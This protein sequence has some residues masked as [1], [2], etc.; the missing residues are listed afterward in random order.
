MSDLIK[1]KSCGQDVSPK[2]KA[3]PKCG[4]P[5]K[6]K[7]RFL[8]I[9][10]V[11]AI[12]CL[13]IWWPI[14]H[15]I[16]SGGSDSQSE[17]A[18][19]QS[20]VPANTTQDEAAPTPQPD[21]PNRQPSIS[22][23]AIYSFP[24]GAN[25]VWLVSEYTNTGSVGILAFKSQWTIV[26]DLGDSQEQ[27]EDKYTSETPFVET[28]GGTNVSAESHIILPGDT[29]EIISQIYQSDSGFEQH[30]SATTQKN[31]ASMLA[32]FG[33]TN[34]VDVR[35]NRKFTFEIEKVVAR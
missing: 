5:V 27:R 29:I 14:I 15:S 32:G 20:E 24:F 33:F 4:A 11:L 34:L 28:V 10:S 6:R 30:I 1:C 13:A 22:L 12:I 2:A 35:D 23:S 25:G 3:C 21:T 8:K 18:Q 31:F 19:Q 7:I 16:I 26:D 17:P 9:M